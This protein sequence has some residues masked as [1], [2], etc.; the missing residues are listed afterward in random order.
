MKFFITLTLISTLITGHSNANTLSVAEIVNRTNLNAFYQG[1]D[2]MGKARM[3]IIDAQGRVQVRQFY[4]LRRDIEE[5][6]DQQF[7]IAFSRP[8]DVKGMIFRVEK[9]TQSDDD[10]W[11]Y[12]PALDLVKRISASDKRTSFV[13]S[14]FFY[15]DISG[16]NTTL[17]N[18][19]LQSQTD[20]HYL[21]KAV[22]K[23]PKTV[24]FK[25]YLLE[26]N[27]SLMLPTKISYTNTNNEVYRIIEA[28]KIITID[29]YPT[30]ISS[31]VSLPLTGARTL[32]QFK[33]IQYNNKIPPH[34]FSERS[35]RH[36]PK[37]WLK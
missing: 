5:G 25:H 7:L 11:L 22:P 18:F 16:R 32:M 28:K 21:I 24:E 35:L 1:D 14:H 17:D 37:R 34:I 3:K 13:G 19:T 4:L 27:K 26:I 23:N 31:Q 6:G 36:P 2:G 8:S 30:V 33:G 12:L 10:R 20:T 9:H 29:D 15:E